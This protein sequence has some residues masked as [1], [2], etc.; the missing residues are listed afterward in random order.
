MTTAAP[1]ITIED[2]GQDLA[3]KTVCLPLASRSLSWRACHPTP[4]IM[5]L[6]VIS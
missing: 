3:Q 5:P 6:D 1:I 4:I 2:R